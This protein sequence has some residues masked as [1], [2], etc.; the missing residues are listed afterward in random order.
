VVRREV[1]LRAEADRMLRQVQ[2]YVDRTILRS[3][4]DSK[5][6]PK[7]AGLHALRHFFAS[8][9][10]NRKADGG[11]ELPLKVVQARLGHATIS[12][13]ADTYSHLFPRQDDGSE[14][15]AAAASL[16]AVPT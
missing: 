9:L 14:L 11:L 12:L 10:I 4:V 3:V 13:T 7:Y 1:E 8:W 6:G 2:D 5:G 16:M 15:T